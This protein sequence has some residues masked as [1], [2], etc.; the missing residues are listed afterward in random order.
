[1]KRIQVKPRSGWKSKVKNAGVLHSLWREDVA[2][3]FDEEEIVD[4]E[5]V[6]NELRPQM[7]EAVEYLLSGEL[8][9]G[10]PREVLEACT[11]S[12]NRKPPTLYGRYDFHYTDD[13]RFELLEYNGDT[14]G[15]VPETAVLQS[16]WLDETFPD[17][18]QFN[19]LQEAVVDR[20]KR[21]KE[22]FPGVPL[23]FAHLGGTQK[24][25]FEDWSNI[26]LVR[27]C[28]EIAG[29]SPTLGMTMQDL[30]WDADRRLFVDPYNLPVDMCFKLYPWSF[31]IHEP[32][33]ALTVSGEDPVVWVEPLWKLVADS[34]MM[35]VALHR[36][37]PDSRTII[38]AV[39]GEENIP[40]WDRVVSK[41][42]FGRSGEGVTIDRP[43][44]ITPSKGCVYQRFSPA[45]QF[46]GYTPVV[47]VW[48]VGDFT[49]GTPAALIM[50]ESRDGMVV[51]DS[52]SVPH[53]YQ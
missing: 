53:W 37:F 14:P 20:W 27:E 6:C 7:R 13:G 25:T 12:W 15:L 40:A 34:K 44:D 18:E 21:I 16:Q 8:D 3:V 33:M 2:Y 36:L 38:P 51:G 35:L 19:F 50:R 47:S 52:Y 28:A 32:Y 10:L 1:M 22:M 48:D 43:R 17:E 9:V 31:M 42:L 24:G 30:T 41:P 5:T 39:T 46:A 4:V 49:E 29:V 23:H 45:K 26:A 11:E